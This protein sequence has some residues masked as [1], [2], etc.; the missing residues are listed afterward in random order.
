ME[1]V[2]TRKVEKY[3]RACLQSEIDNLQALE[4]LVKAC[5][6]ASPINPVKHAIEI[7]FSVVEQSVI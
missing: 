6:I 3:E 5:S 7:C 1:A 4:N 2:N